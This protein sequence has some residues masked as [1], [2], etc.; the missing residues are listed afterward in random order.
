MP[1]SPAATKL[2]PLLEDA[3]SLGAHI[4]AGEIRDD[5]T[6]LTPLVLGGVSPA[7][8]LLRVDIFEAVLC[9]VTVTDD[10]EALLRA[11]DCPFAL[12]G[13]IFSRDETAA[14][15]L[16]ARLNAGVVTINDVI[17][18]TADARV[19][20]GGRGRSGFGSTRGAEGLLELTTPKVVTVSRSKFRP[21]FDPPQAGDEEMFQAYLM[22]THG[23]GWKYRWHAL[24]QLIGTLI[25]RRK[26]GT[27]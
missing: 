14:R 24:K 17:V 6:V 23:R 18:S 5:G 7:S 2:R 16:A 4:I 12:A 15:A 1:A 27:V 25:R 19:P 9:I 10:H 3:L 11:N 13:S 8:R 26:G 21:A 22:L 20:F